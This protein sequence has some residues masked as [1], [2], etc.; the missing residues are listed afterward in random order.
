MRVMAVSLAAFSC[1][2]IGHAE[3]KSDATA[4]T[5][6]KLAAFTWL[7]GKWQTRNDSDV[8][9][10]HYMAPQY[11]CMIGIFRW[12]KGGKLWM[13]ELLSITAEDGQVIFR[14]KHFDAKMVGWEEKDQSLNWKLA[15]I[16]GPDH[17][18][19]NPEQKSASR[20]TLRRNGDSGLTVV[21]E[22]EKDGK[23][24][25]LEGFLENLHAA[26]SN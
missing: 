26:A 14:L 19:E 17:I 25:K 16:E 10:E 22:G 6:G 12:V 9:E 4:E 23:P 7:A 8:L 18:F 20:F 3:T 13:F 15:R 5:G 11:D 24:S 1:L 2:S 21:L